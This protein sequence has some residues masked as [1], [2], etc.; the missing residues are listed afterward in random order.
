MN[1]ENQNVNNGSFNNV[2]GSNSNS[3]PINSNV[4]AVPNP[5][6]VNPTVGAVPNPIPVNP[7]I[8]VVPNPMPVDSNVGAVPNPMPVDPN[9]GAV[10][11]PMPVDP[12]VGA[13]PNQM[14]VNPSVGAVPNPMPV[15]P[16][17][18]AVSNP[19]PVSPN[20][21]A[22]SN[23]MPVNNVS[24]GFVN[25]QPEGVVT[26]QASVPENA[27]TV[28]PLM[29]TD[30]NA[31]SGVHLNQEV[32]SQ[33]TN[34]VMN[35][36]VGG[37]S[38]NNIGMMGGVPV[39]P[40]PIEES[41]DNKK[42]KIKMNKTLL[43]VLV[44]VLIAAV[45][46]GVYY[47]LFASKKKSGVTITA[48]MPDI[49]QLG[50][51]L[52]NNISSYVRVSGAD[53]NSCTLTSNLDTSV[54]GTYKWSVTCGNTSTGEKTVTV[55]DTTAPVVVTQDV[56]VVPNTVVTADEFIA[57]VD[58]ASSVTY[59]FADG[60]VDTSTPGSYTVSIIASDEFENQTTVTATLIVDENAPVSYLTCS[61]EEVPINYDT[62]VVT[63]SYEYGL[64]ATALYDQK[65]VVLYTFSALED[66]EAAATEISENG[67]DGYN[68]MVTA[69]A[70]DYTIMIEIPLTVDELATEFNQTPFPTSGTEIE[71]LHTTRGDMCTTTSI[72]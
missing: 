59:E 1:N 40:A 45:G 63:V 46:G 34:T 42:K 15:N 7:N 62:A 30:L 53:I 35:N 3:T 8:G 6:P 43:I 48:L 51:P 66:Y 2:M 5:T 70:D 49:V 16:S 25:L 26:P 32:S 69:N 61:Y 37:V 47:F 41:H 24:D 64:G 52:N 71:N 31:Q 29:G 65:K 9:V 4:G 20:V 44:V 23:A 57:S 56:A 18:G 17:V 13:V 54:A 38:N 67:F 21:G 36:P 55:R 27:N 11:N 10:P 39:P 22:A 19:T 12:N 60:S 33:L 68:G 72:S 58:D 28:Q 50:A 14:P